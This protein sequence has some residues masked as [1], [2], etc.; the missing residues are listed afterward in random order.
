MG[1][2]RRA[3]MLAALLGG[4]FLGNVDTAVANTAIPAI[5]VGLHAAGVALDLVVSGY[6]LA[7]AALLVTS[8]RLGHHRGHRRTF[9]LGLSVFTLASVGCGVA[10]DAWALVVARIVQAAGAALMAAQ[11]LTLLQLQFTGP[12]RARA[13][14]L[15]TVV[16]SA[17]AIV[18][19]VAGGLLISADLLG[20]GWRSVFL[21]NGP[22][23]GLL[24]VL[25]VA[26]LPADPPG[27]TGRL[28]W[29]GVLALSAALL[30]LVVPLV[31]GPEQGWHAWTGLC[32]V[33]SLPAL[34]AFHALQRRVAAAGGRPIID[35]G[36]LAR[37]LVAWGAA[38]IGTTA[39]TY[40]ATLFVVA[41]YLQRGLGYTAAASGLALRPWVA[42]FGL[43]GPLLP[44]L[45]GRGQRQ[46][47][48]AGALLMVVGFTGIA[49][50]A[51]PA[52]GGLLAGLLGLCGLGY[53]LAYSALVLQLTRAVAVTHAADL[54]GLIQT[55][56]RIG[57]VVG[58][59]AFG[60]GYLAL[61]PAPGPALA[62]TAFVRIAA[63]LAV[64]ALA[65]AAMA[66]AAGRAAAPPAG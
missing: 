35:P 3:W 42:A 13:L 9:L 58:V 6:S 16:L 33:L 11:V 21:V 56:S 14:G 39:S 57:G 5:Q 61:A 49:L 25:G 64:T 4:L 1:V 22:A 59:A 50:F 48:P 47:G 55:A 46:A 28:D 40:F 2:R 53:G 32:L 45:S 23:G 8:A 26:V 66:Q 20:A 52:R 24:F 51:G 27:R 62:V 29:T 65:G 15:Y 63:A 60:A 17:G 7:Y 34:A 38:A 36:L 37:R 43:A 12:T 30:L 44:R 19:Q 10:P 31:I 18:G 54:S 41:L